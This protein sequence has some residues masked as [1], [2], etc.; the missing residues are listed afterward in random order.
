MKIV[1]IGGGEI[2]RPKKEGGRYPIETRK[3]DKEIIRLTG[4]AHPYA[5]LLPTASG[6]SEIYYPTF[7]RYYGKML[8]CR[9]DALYLIKE[10]PSLSEI[11]QKV[12]K[13]D[14]IYVGGGN[15]LKMLKVWRKTGFDKILEQVA[16]E[17][18]I[19]S[20]VS[21]GALCWFK[22]GYSDSRRFGSANNQEFMKLR[23][24]DFVPLMA[25]PHYDIEESR[26]PCLH[27]YIKHH[28]GSVIALDNGAAFEYIDGKYR[29][30]TSLPNANAYRIYKVNGKAVEEKLEINGD[31]K[32]VSELREIK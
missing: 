22:Y 29:I 31:F 18:K 28:G 10:N 1:A 20:G 23:G 7:E 6:D 2:G 24:L 9:T 14:I 25:C 8:G 17:G 32:P 16:E 15:T 5:L 27:K 30:L 19:L 3:I 12:A 26:R 11:N 21:A 13:A 4:K